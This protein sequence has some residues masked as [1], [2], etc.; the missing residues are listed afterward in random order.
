M[1]IN[2]IGEILDT[3]F[4]LS[5][6]WARWKNIKGQRVCFLIWTLCAGYWCARDLYLCLYSQSFFCFFS[7]CLNL[8]GFYNWKNKGIGDAVKQS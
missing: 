4:S 6:K 5:G 2:W 7:V 8:Y 1:Q 3:I